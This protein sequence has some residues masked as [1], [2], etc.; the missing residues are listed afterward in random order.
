MGSV[1]NEHFGSFTSGGGVTKSRTVPPG[2]AR[3][4]PCPLDRC[5]RSVPAPHPAVAE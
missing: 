3:D 4:A 5:L 1:R 2:P